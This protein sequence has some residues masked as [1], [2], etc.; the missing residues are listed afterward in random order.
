[1][2]TTKLEAKLRHL[3]MMIPE[4]ILQKEDN[5]LV[6]SNFTIEIEGLTS[7]E[8]EL[9]LDI[10]YNLLM[11]ATSLLDTIEHEQDRVQGLRQET[12]Y[13]KGMKIEAYN[14]GVADAMV[15]LETTEAISPT[16]RD[17]LNELNQKLK[18]LLIHADENAVGE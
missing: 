10:V 3:L 7:V 12:K 6:A 4:I 8:N 9:Y 17:V 11:N 14:K 1:M 2:S 15:M 5:K 18:G 16:S 13:K